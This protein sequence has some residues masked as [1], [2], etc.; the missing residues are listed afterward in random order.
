LALGLWAFSLLGFG[1]L[2]IWALGLLLCICAF[3]HLCIW[4]LGLLGSWALGLLGIWF[5]GIW[6]LSLWAL[7]LLGFCADLLEVPHINIHLKHFNVK[8]S[9]SRFHFFCEVN[10]TLKINFRYSI[11][12]RYKTIFFIQVVDFFQRTFCSTIFS[13]E[14]VV[15]ARLLYPLLLVF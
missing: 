14:H 1:H 12:S 2:S 13:R 10:N 11:S 9:C 6:D 5:L 15:L 4:S 3:V 8:I 7:G